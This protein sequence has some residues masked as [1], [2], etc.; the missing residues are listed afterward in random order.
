M[1]SLYLTIKLNGLGWTPF[2]SKG[3]GDPEEEGYKK[4]AEAIAKMVS[5]D[6]YFVDRGPNKKTVSIQIRGY[7][8]I[9]KN[10]LV[11]NP[12]PDSRSIIL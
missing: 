3:Q 6:P 1:A 10:V 4:L 5:R 12:I 8:P 2:G 11:T 7:D 9:I